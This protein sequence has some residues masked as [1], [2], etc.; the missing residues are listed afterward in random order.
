MEAFATYKDYEQRY[1]VVDDAEQVDMLLADISVYVLNAYEAYW[2]AT[3]KEGDHPE[4]DRAVVGV[5]C[6]IAHRCLS[7]PAAFAG[8][9]Q[10]SQTAGSYNASATF[11]NPTGDIYLGTTDYKRLGL[12]GQRIDAVFPIVGDVQC[13]D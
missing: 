3:Y 11:S 7:V 4:F 2:G 13:Q 6:S 1:G 5:C 8:V 9:S 10:Y 12:Y